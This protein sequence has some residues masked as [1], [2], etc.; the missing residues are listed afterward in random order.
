[1]RLLIVEDEAYLAKLLRRGF[2]EEGYLVDVVDDGAK[3]LAAAVAVPYDAAI[4]DVMLPDLDGFEVCV[5][6][7]RSDCQIPVLMLTAR[8]TVT[9]RI[10]GL[11]AGADD[12][13]CKPFSFAELCAR[14][15]ALTRRKG[16]T[17]QAPVQLRAGR[18]RLDPLSRR[19]WSGPSEVYLSLKEFVLLEL[20]MR[21][22]D[23][24]LTRSRIL[25]HVWGFRYPVTSNVVEQY[26]RSLRRKLGSDVI[27]TV[28]GMGYRMPA[29][30]S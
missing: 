30:P 19:V 29:A 17:V 6:L 13:L 16:T 7:R 11:D 5:R 27:V 14:I 10:R 28:R 3:G 8:D 12:Y 26:I 20:L 25:D 1:M 4:L 9:D 2:A 22:P 23:E 18:V 15:R 21:H 24:V